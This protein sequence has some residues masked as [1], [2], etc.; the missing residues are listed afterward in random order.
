MGME[1]TEREALMEVPEKTEEIRQEETQQPEKKVK[2]RKKDKP[3]RSGRGVR[4]MLRIVQHIVLAVMAFSLI[5]ITVSSTVQVKKFRSGE[6]VSFTG[7]QDPGVPFEDSEI[8]NRIFGYAVADIVRFGVVCSQM[9][10]DGA[11]D[12]SRLVDVTAYNYRNS[13][14][15]EE[16]VSAVYRLEDLL[17][18]HNYGFTY[19]TVMLTEDE[20]EAFF[21]GSAR[22]TT[23]K[24]FNSELREESI[25]KTPGLDDNSGFV[26]DYQS[27]DELGA[28]AGAET[29]NEAV[30]QEEEE[31]GD[32]AVYAYDVLVNRYKT[33]DGRNLEDCVS[34]WSQYYA[35]I[36]NVRQAA[37]SL[38]YN[39]D[40]YVEY[41]EYY[42]TENSNVRYL[43]EKTVGENVLYYSNMEQGSPYREKVMQ[44]MEDLTREGK[45]ARLPYEKFIYYSPADMVY[46]TNT[47]IGESTLRQILQGYDYAYPENTRIWIG[48]DT[49]Y[50]ARDAF[51]QGKEYLPNLWL[52]VAAAIVCGLLYLLL[53][54]YQT[55]TTGR[56]YDETGVKRI[57]LHAFDE[58]PTEGAL[59]IAFTVML[60]AG[61][62]VVA[63]T[64]VAGVDPTDMDFYR[65]AVHEEWFKAAV[66]GGV[67]V[68]DVLFTFFF[69]SLVRRIKAGVLIQNSYLYRLFLGLKRFAWKVYDNGGIVLR[70]WVLYGCFLLVNLVLIFFGSGYGEW[71][72]LIFLGI[73]DVFAGVLLYK[74]VKERQGIVKGIET[75]AGGQVEYQIDT[76]ELHGDN[77]VLAASVNSIGKGIKE[78][79]EISMKDERM[80]A[81]LV[82]NVSHDIKTPLTSIINYVDLLKRERV[83]NEKIQGYIRVLDEKS[84]RLK[85]LTD[86]LVEASKITSGNISLHFERINMTE[87]MNQTIGEFS[88]KFETKNLTTVMNVNTRDVVIEADSR[89]IWRVMENLFNNIFKYAMPGTRVYVS[90]SKPEGRQ[91]G[92]PEQIEIAIKNISENPLNCK[93]E[94]LTE[95]FIRG[96]ES[97]TT[98]GSGLGLSIAKNLTLA[99]RGSFEIELDGD[100]FKVF[101]TFPVVIGT[102]T[103][104]EAK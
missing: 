32:S 72:L 63:V 102:E 36:E 41:G 104:K 29:V 30:L 68:A 9:E 42:S 4:T 18:W 27:I 7:Y 26:E 89:R 75:I 5:V 82:T 45:E 23:Q 20:E 1:N 13:V 14:L 35:L 83:D 56:E 69:Y 73:I 88:E 8:F 17:K 80:K 11:F 24:D 31:D 53:F 79:V 40:E 70:T 25:I 78:A 74:D 67:F 10:T 81:D 54:L 2:K 96:D 87:L 33:A 34:N 76:Q 21:S 60:L 98:E 71:I 65:E 47:A 39:Y 84:Q 28:H 43:I 19:S 94:E 91:P 61:W 103:E 97:R 15:P 95:R 22:E 48:V 44:L 37:E 85:Q 50:P 51:T 93:P 57:R 49:S 38:S 64:M 6:S 46:Q 52:W 100:L 62:I 55:V 59:V 86:D 90:M 16:Y 92:E 66:L 101:L 77:K 3:K 12:G 99:Q 58:I